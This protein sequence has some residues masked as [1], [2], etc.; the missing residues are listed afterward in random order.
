[1]GYGR[2]DEPERFAAELKRIE[3]AYGLQPFDCR[4]WED[5]AKWEAYGRDLDQRYP[6]EWDHEEVM[7]LQVK[8][9]IRPREQVE[10]GAKASRCA[11]ISARSART[12]TT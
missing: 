3:D 12:S 9:G 5:L 4:T 1:M 8:H 10:G 2:T 6:D 11:T 7:D